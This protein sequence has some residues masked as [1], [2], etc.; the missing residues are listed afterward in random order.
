MRSNK[1]SRFGINIY[2]QVYIDYKPFFLYKN[3][4]FLSGYND[5][6][7]NKWFA[8]QIEIK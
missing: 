1:E 6:M 5:F 4:S 8:P 3:N 7:R 2:N